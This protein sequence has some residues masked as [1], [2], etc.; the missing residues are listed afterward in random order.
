MGRKAEN[1]DAIARVRATTE[2]HRQEA[3]LGPSLP[4]FWP[5]YL[6]TVSPKWAWRYRHTKML[7]EAVDRVHRGESRRLLISV[8]PRHFKSETVTVRYSSYFLEENPERR[9]IVGAYAQALANRFSRKIRRIV[10]ERVPLSNER[11]AAEEWETTKSGGLRAVGVGSGITGFGADLIIVDDPVKNREQ[12]ESESYRERV[13]EWF[14]DDLYTRLEP[15]GAIIVIQTRWHEDDLFGRLVKQMEEEDGEKWEV[16]NL[17]ALAEEDDPLGRQVDEALCPQRY[18]EAALERIRQKLGEYSFA[19]LYQGRPTARDGGL[20][21]VDKINAIDPV[22]VPKG[23]KWVRYWDLAQSLKSTASFTASWAMAIDEQGRIFCRDLVRGRLEW[24]DLKRLMIDVFL[25]DP[26][27]T[28]GIEAKLQ[29][30]SAVQ[31]FLRDPKILHCSIKKMDVDTDKVTRA[32]P[33]AD[34]LNNG[35][36]Y[37]VRGPYFV[38]EGFAAT[39]TA[40]KGQILCRGPWQGH[41]K[42][43]LTTFPKGKTNDIVDTGSGGTLMIAKPQSRKGYSW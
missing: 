21:Q 36:V 14:N 35:Q 27:V 7:S 19:A 28:Q 12:A 42:G 2:Q 11:N 18:D 30:L 39:L 5:T 8:P 17:P 3:G 29:G 15:D 32:Q 41:A 38:P 24:P 20:F 34:R 25:S 13:W 10:E 22:D 43:E 31:E 6:E 40:R 1:N 4:A 9:V 23:L 33:F 26:K 16:L 37:F